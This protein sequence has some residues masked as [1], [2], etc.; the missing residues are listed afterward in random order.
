LPVADPQEPT[1]TE[2]P[3][4]QN[5][6][7]TGETEPTWRST[8]T[9]QQVVMR[10]SGLFPWWTVLGLGILSVLL[11]IVVLAWPEAT[12]RV[13]AALAGLWLVLG[14]LMR[15]FNAF[16]AGGGVGRQVLSG[17][18]GVVLVLGG[19]FCLRNIV[20]T[21]ALLALV[22]AVTWLLSGIAEMVM[23][24]EATGGNRMWLIVLGV[25]SLVIGLV[26]L[27]TPE[28]SL[29]TLVLT[30]GMGFIVTGAIQVVFGI[31]LRRHRGE[32]DN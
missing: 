2:I 22:V 14:G 6:D 27:I 24:F 10:E 23:A 13:M 3:A 31:N 30:T 9:S 26:F 32:A 11:G 1:M 18:V 25:V 28:L 12:V 16:V 4:P 20:T 5:L 29:Y 19:A 8:V 15:I 21:A 17:I 7:A